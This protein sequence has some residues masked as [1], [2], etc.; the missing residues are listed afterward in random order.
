MDTVADVSFFLSELRQGPF[1]YHLAIDGKSFAALCDHFPEYLPKV[2]W[3]V[4]SLWE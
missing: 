2:K 3:A 1:D 4:Y